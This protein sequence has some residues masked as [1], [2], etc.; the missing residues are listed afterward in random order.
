M[1]SVTWNLLVVE[2][3]VPGAADGLAEMGRISHQKALKG[4]RSFTA[5]SH[6]RIYSGASSGCTSNCHF[7]PFTCSMVVPQNSRYVRLMN[8]APPSALV[9]HIIAGQ[10]S[11]MMRK[12]SSLSRSAS[13]VRLRSVIS[14]TWTTTHC[15]SAPEPR[16]AEISHAPPHHR[17]IAAN[18]AFFRLRHRSGSSDSSSPIRRESSGSSGSVSCAQLVPTSSSSL[19][20]SIRQSAA[21]T[22]VIRPVQTADNYSERGML[23]HSAEPLFAFPQ[24]PLDNAMSHIH[25]GCALSI[26]RWFSSFL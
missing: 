11:A 26:Y 14:S 12:R 19:C 4:A 6:A 13:S 9:T 22:W 10:L 5:R 7:P 17:S 18:V 24:F 2:A 21:L 23:K 1:D 8:C 15:R 3:V 20:S 16:T 25:S